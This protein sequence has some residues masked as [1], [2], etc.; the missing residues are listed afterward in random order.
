ML[1]LS[2]RTQRLEP[3]PA[4]LGI[5]LTPHDTLDGGGE[6][7][8]LEALSRPHVPELHHVVSRAG[9]EESRGSW[10]IASEMSAI[11][12]EVP[13]KVLYASSNS[14]HPLDLSRSSCTTGAPARRKRRWSRRARRIGLGPPPPAPAVPHRFQSLQ[15]PFRTP[16]SPA[17]ALQRP[18]RLHRVPFFFDRRLQL[19][20]FLCCSCTATAAPVHSD[21]AVAVTHS[22]R[23]W[24]RRFRCGHRK[25]RDALHCASARR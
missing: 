12:S 7:P 9:N 2:R 18:T 24:S 8:C 16:F 25:F 21:P 11:G 4:H 5:V 15:H 3:L 20:S 13:V 10:R 1:S 17:A 6:L 19:C 14:P 22:R 23:R